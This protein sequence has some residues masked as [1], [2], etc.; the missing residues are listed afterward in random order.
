MPSIPLSAS[1]TPAPSIYERAGGQ[2]TFFR[3]CANFYNRVADDAVLRP[4]YPED[5][6][7]SAWWLGPVFDPVL[8]RAGRL[9]PATRPPARLRMR[10]LPFKVGQAERDAWMNNMRAAVE[11]EIQDDEVKAYLLEYFERTATFMMNAE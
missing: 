1:S 7:D 4:I 11:E 3:L 6:K 2:P 9:L 5:L 10:H 8:R